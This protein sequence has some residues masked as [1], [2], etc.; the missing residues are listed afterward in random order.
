MSRKASTTIPDSQLGRAVCVRAR[1][2]V[3]RARWGLTAS[4]SSPRLSSSLYCLS[5]FIPSLLP[6][7]I[8]PLPPS[9]LCCVA[10]LPFYLPVLTVSLTPLSILCA[11]TP[12]YLCLLSPS[13]SSCTLP[14]PPFCVPCSIYPPFYYY[15]FLSFSMPINYSVFSLP[16][17]TPLLVSLAAY[18]KSM[19]RPM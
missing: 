7:S 6:S 10:F 13:L 2:C 8:H 11:L 19:S 5:S 18:L 17:P 12:L 14:K 1:V 16:N 3:T 9:T 4:V 15:F